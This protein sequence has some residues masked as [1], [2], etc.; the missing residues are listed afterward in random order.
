MK[1]NT[2]EKAHAALLNMQPEIILG[3]AA[4][5]RRGAD[6]AHAGAEQVSAHRRVALVENG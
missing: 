6:P 2:L 5:A 4:E 3:A 1:M